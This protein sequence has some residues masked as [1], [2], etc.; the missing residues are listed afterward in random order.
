[1]AWCGVVKRG[2]GSLNVSVDTWGQC[3]VCLQNNTEN[4]QTHIQQMN[5]LP[6]FLRDVSV[7]CEQT[8]VVLGYRLSNLVTV[9]VVLKLAI[10]KETR[11][12]RI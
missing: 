7:D 3:G 6:I 10:K 11:Y 4:V 1:M 8:R 2:V 9:M 12:A 5:T